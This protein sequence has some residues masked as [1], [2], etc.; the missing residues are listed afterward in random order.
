MHHLITKN[1]MNDR[2][3]LNIVYLAIAGVAM[4]LLMAM[5]SCSNQNIVS[6]KKITCTDRKSTR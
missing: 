3:K 2:M 1:I 6:D 4:A 5:S